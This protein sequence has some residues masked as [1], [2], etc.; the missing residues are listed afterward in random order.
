MIL[1]I[2]LQVLT[3]VSGSTTLISTTKAG[4]YGQRKPVHI[5]KAVLKETL[6]PAFLNT[7]HSLKSSFIY[8]GVRRTGYS[9]YDTAL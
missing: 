8:R 4:L 9:T 3:S 6:S 5:L 2:Y 1:P 7:F